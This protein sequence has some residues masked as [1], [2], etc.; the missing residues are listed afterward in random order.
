MKI[1]CPHCQY[2]GNKFE[3]DTGSLAGTV[4]NFYDL[5]E[6]CDKCRRPFVVHR[7]YIRTIQ[8]LRI[9]PH[10]SPA[11]PSMQAEGAAVEPSG[12]TKSPTTPKGDR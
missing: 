3:A 4:C 9:E 12:E 1:K 2:D 11:G 6:E 10:T 5:I 8:C 7:N